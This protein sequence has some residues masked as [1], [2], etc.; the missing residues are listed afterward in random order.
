VTEIQIAD[1]LSKIAGIRDILHASSSE[2]DDHPSPDESI[3]SPIHGYSHQGFLFGY[4]STMNSL[5]N[6]H[7]SPAQTSLLWQAFKENV[8]PVVKIFH[9]PTVGKMIME[10]R[11]HANISR[12]AEALLFGVYYG[13]VVSLDTQQCQTLL[14]E[15]KAE[16]LMR[17][18][19]AVEQAL[20]RAGFLSTSSL[21]TLQAFVFFLVCV[22]YQDYSRI[23]WSLSGLAIH[24]AQALGVH[25]D[26][27]HFG[28]TPFETEMRRRLWWHISILDARAAEDH[29]TDPSLSEQF[30]DT[31]LPLNIN[32]DEISP[33]T[34]EAPR[35]H[36]GTTEM[37]F[38][39]IRFELSTTTRQL[40][41]VPPGSSPSPSEPTTRTLEEKN[42]I[43][44][45]CRQR[46][47][48]RYIQ[49]CDTSVPIQWVC[50][51]VARIILAKLWLMAH[52]TSRANTTSAW[53]PGL[54]P[55]NIRERFYNTSLEVV[56]FS[57]VLISN[58]NTAKWG[59]LFR[60]YMHWRPVIFILAELC[61][62]APGPEFERGWRAVELVLSQEKLQEVQKGL[63]WQPLN[64]LFEK[65][66]SVR[67]QHKTNCLEAATNAEQMEQEQ[68]QNPIIQGNWTDLSSNLGQSINII[69]STAAALG[70][71]LRDMDPQQ[72]DEMLGMELH[73]PI[74]DAHGWTENFPWN[75]INGGTYPVGIDGGM[76]NTVSNTSP[77]MTD[78]RGVFFD[79]DVSYAYM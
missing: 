36:T 9:R 31:K 3:S 73:D 63:L 67:E 46:I 53:Q 70:L 54:Q 28:L 19:F 21:M 69:S 18:R 20:T 58:E 52:H 1:K 43:I 10:S 33:S 26:G 37:T 74:L 11:D 57:H 15:P 35:E 30:S 4:S 24:L 38:C 56:E 78:Q 41:F 55:E 51:T 12:P 16:L 44:E 65:A 50:A 76:A 32:D 59:W 45:A 6:L 68:S 7:P 39:L 13:A 14:G 62:G 49:H 27:T 23:V 34:T 40:N 48:E 29:S 2:E 71:D 61:V 42:N 79:A 75:P 25:R 5:R 17:Y 66:N 60:T 77:N 8:D 64:Q 22:R 72:N 47:E